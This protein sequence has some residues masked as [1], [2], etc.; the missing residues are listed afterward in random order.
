[1]VRTSKNEQFSLLHSIVLV[2]HFTRIKTIW[3]LFS[4]SFQ[5]INYNRIWDK[6]LRKKMQYN[7]KLQISQH[8]LIAIT[9]FIQQIESTFR[10]VLI[11]KFLQTILKFKKKR[12]ERKLNWLLSINQH[13]V[14]V[15][16]FKVV[17]FVCFLNEGTD[18]SWFCSSFV[19]E[20]VMRGGERVQ[21]TQKPS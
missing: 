8:F 1:M 4:I 5:I 2:V 18:N 14:T 9:L 15:E 12:T 13:P 16:G 17:T 11:C 7:I 19:V 3:K 10:I 6:I 20:E 21:G